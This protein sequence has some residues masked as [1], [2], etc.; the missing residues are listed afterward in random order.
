MDALESVFVPYRDVLLPQQPHTPK[1]SSWRWLW[2]GL[3]AILGVALAWVIFKG[4]GGFWTPSAVVQKAFLDPPAVLASSF[5]PPSAPVTAPVVVTSFKA[6]S[7]ASVPQSISLIRG[8]AA[9]TDLAKSPT[10]LAKQVGLAVKATLLTFPNLT[11]D[12]VASIVQH[13]VRT[14]LGEKTPKPVSAPAVQPSV[15]APPVHKPDVPVSDTV[16]SSTPTAPSGGRVPLHGKPIPI[17]VEDEESQ[18]G[19]SKQKKINAESDPAVL[20]LMKERGLELKS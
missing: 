17:V 6:P 15:T 5:E 20:R 18:E 10:D 19:G 8:G 13:T 9:P 3:V 14:I 11:P 4:K 7:F 1:P 16:V 2:L 12:M